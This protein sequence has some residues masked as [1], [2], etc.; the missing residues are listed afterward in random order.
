MSATGDDRNRARVVNG[1]MALTR[2]GEAA[3]LLE[4]A[5]TDLNNMDDVPMHSTTLILKALHK[6][7]TEAAKTEAL[8]TGFIARC[9]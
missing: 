1:V 8:L 9:P 2:I 4:R 5:V 7:T 6:A 3:R